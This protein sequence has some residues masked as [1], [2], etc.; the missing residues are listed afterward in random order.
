MRVAT[1]DYSSR[2]IKRI[3]IEVNADDIGPFDK[4][5]Y[6][7]EEEEDWLN[8]RTEDKFWERMWA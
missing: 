8:W 4:I 7:K 1:Y 3:I 6:S 5:L 2:E